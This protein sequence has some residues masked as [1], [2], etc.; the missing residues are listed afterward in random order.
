MAEKVPQSYS[1]HR[2]FVPGYHFVLFLILVVNLGVTLYQLWKHGIAFGAAW[3]VVMAVALILIALY[4]RTFPLAAQDRLIRL[5]ERLRYQRL[6]PDDLKLRIDEI[7]RNQVIALRFAGDDEVADLARA[8]LDEGLND[9][10]AI[11]KRI[12]NWRGDDLRV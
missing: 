8:V 2:R 7:T 1:N 10:E 6:F 12:R 9:R 4:A 5:E 11:K 3:N